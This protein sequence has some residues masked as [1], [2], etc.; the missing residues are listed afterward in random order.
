MLDIEEVQAALE[1]FR[2]D[3]EYFEVHHTDFLRQYPD[4]WVAVYEE[5][6]IAADPNLERLV[7]TLVEKGLPP[8]HSVVRYLNSEEET[9]LLHG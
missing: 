9:L 3:G 2:K 4:Q 1:H 8:E 5:Q 6:F 7:R